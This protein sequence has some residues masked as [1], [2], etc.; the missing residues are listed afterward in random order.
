TPS[1]P[2][3]PSPTPTPTNSQNNKPS[4]SRMVVFGDSDFITDGFF[5]QQLNGDVFLNS[6][7]WLSKQDSQPLSIR[8]KEAKNRRINLSQAQANLLALSSILV[9]PILA[10]ASAALLWFQRR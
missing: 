8:P 4:E 10:F 6:V 2:S 1:P 5:S 3:S 7:T 9:L